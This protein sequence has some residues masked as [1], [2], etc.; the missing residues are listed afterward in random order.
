MRRRA[1]AALALAICAAAPPQA[2]MAAGRANGA[3]LPQAA[4]KNVFRLCS[5]GT[6]PD[7]MAP[8]YEKLLAAAAVGPVTTWEVER[9]LRAGQPA[10]GKNA[11][12]YDQTADCV[13]RTL[14]R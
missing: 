10:S 6:P 14:G 1:L 8:V 2:A 5:G 13:V 11:E 9:R 7:Y 3:P 12:M 4:I